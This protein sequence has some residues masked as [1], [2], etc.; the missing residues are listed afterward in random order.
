MTVIVDAMWNFLSQWRGKWTSPPC[1]DI[2]VTRVIRARPKPSAFGNDYDGPTLLVEAWG[3]SG[4]GLGGS[5]MV[6]KNATT[7]A[8]ATGGDAGTLVEAV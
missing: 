7:G 1:F 5:E 4:R 3:S 2:M 8:A 6:S